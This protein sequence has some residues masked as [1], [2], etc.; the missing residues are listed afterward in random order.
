VG[1]VSWSLKDIVGC[2]Y[3]TVNH[4][5]IPIYYSS[6]YTQDL[7]SRINASDNV[8]ERHNTHEQE[9]KTRDLVRGRCFPQRHLW[10]LFGYLMILVG[11]PCL[12]LF[13]YR[14]EQRR[15]RMRLFC[16]QLQSKLL[17]IILFGYLFLGGGYFM[18]KDIVGCV[19]FISIAIAIIVYGSFWV[20]LCLSI[21]SFYF[22]GT[23][24][25]EEIVG[26]VY[27]IWAGDDW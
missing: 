12:F 11:V 4:N 1:A 5:W 26:C 15:R 19:Y 10:F 3:S 2:V 13:G 22:L 6:F 21:L 9:P 14:I 7:A 27:S 20:P 8:L 17:F 25:I 16:S 18:I 24:L 23:L